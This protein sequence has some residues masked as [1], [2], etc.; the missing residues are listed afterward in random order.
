MNE[1][2][3]KLIRKM[4]YKN[5]DSKEREYTQLQNNQVISDLHRSVYRDMKK[6]CRNM[7]KSEIRTHL[8]SKNKGEQ[9]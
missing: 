9:K 4:V 6:E 8:S 3:A 5:A 7:T 1:Q 2:K